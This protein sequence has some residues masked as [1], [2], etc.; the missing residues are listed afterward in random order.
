MDKGKLLTGRLEHR[1]VEIP[2]VGTIRVRGLSRAEVLAVQDAAGPDASKQDIE[3]HTM[4]AAMIDPPMTVD[5]IRQWQASSP[6]GEME[7]A[8][9]AVSELCRVGRDDAKAAYK[10]VRRGRG[11]R[12]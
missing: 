7:E 4:A 10:S 5:E 9:R 1:D 12:T 6:A 2:G 8:T 11:A 3:A